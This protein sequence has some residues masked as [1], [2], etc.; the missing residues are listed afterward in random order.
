MGE[1]ARNEV[2]R[3][4][5]MENEN[6][7]QIGREIREGLERMRMNGLTRNYLAQKK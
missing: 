2:E 5:G 4:G 7:E 3:V 6:K 1:K